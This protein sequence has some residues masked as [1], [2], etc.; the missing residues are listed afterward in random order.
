MKADICA[1][2]D[3]PRRGSLKVELFGRPLHVV[4]TGEGRP[5]AYADVCLHFGGP[6]E[7]RDDGVFECAWRGTRAL[8]SP[9]LQPPNH[10][11]C[12]SPRST[13]TGC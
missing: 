5:V 1:V 7:C 2:A 3:I 11:S 12:A 6:L 13:R 9:A 4:M 10:A 8:A